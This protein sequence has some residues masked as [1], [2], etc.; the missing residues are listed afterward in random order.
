MTDGEPNSTQQEAHV[1]FTPATPVASGKPY[2]VVD[3]DD[4]TPD[5]LD[6][7]VGD[8]AFNIDT[9]SGTSRVRGV[10]RIDGD[11]VRFVEKDAA[12]SKDVRVWVVRE[13]Q[14]TGFTAE[15]SA[16]F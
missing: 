13:G 10:G 16:A 11:A 12:T 5:R 7:F 6:D 1:S 4:R 2:Q 8:R 9:G 3:L 14:S 15:Q